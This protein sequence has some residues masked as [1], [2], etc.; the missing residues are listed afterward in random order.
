MLEQKLSYDRK[1]EVIMKKIL[2]PMAAMA[3]FAA[4]SD[5]ND[6]A[7]PAAPVA[8]ASSSSEATPVA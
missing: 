2:I 4:C 8:G 3:F 5:T 7:F 6:N 1:N